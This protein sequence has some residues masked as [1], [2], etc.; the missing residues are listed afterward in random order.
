MF[1]TGQATPD[2]GVI[3]RDFTVGDVPGV[4]WTPES[5][6]RGAPL[7][8]MGHGGGLHKRAD[9]LAARA[10]H[11]VRTRGFAVASI[12]A[13]GHGD[14]PRDARDQRW[15]A[16]LRRARAA[17]EPIRP[18]VAEF[19]A[20]LAERA[21]PEW[22]AVLDA[23]QAQPEIGPTP[24]GYSGMTLASAIGVPLAAAEPR[25]AAAVFGGIFA[26]DALIEAARRVTVP[27][28]VLL[29]WEDPEIDRQSALD[30][31]DALGSA[32]KTLRAKPVGHTQWPL[33]DAEVSA[34]FFARHLA[35]PVPV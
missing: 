25:I 9:G 14:R 10:R 35:R 33:A 22:R 8:L 32:D 6:A 21:V 11:A 1:F 12:D 16:D 23:L 3:E 34:A 26:Y 24:V 27:V 31:F 30:L 20:S 5:G 15:V 7:I 18:V 13:P 29:P 28:E 2:D 19:N 17:G 4:L